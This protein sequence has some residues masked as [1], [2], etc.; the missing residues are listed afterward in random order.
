[1]GFLLG[2]MNAAPHLDGH[3]E[4]VGLGLGHAGSPN[5]QPYKDNGYGA[6]FAMVACLILSMFTVGVVAASGGA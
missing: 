5:F 2:L 6:L 4:P 1:M 3:L